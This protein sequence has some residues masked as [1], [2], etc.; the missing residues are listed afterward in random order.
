MNGLFINYQMETKDK[1]RMV[2]CVKCGHHK[3]YHAKDMCR[4]CYTNRTNAR[5]RERALS[6]NVIF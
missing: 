5:K 2:D 1:I 3:K 4:R 6:P